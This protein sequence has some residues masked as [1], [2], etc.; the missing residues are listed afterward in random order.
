MGLEWQ[1]IFENPV[2]IQITE[3]FDDGR[4][5]SGELKFKDKTV[6]VKEG[7]PRF[8][9]D[10]YA[11]NFGIQW[12]H[13]R[14]TQFDSYTKMPL[15]SKRFWGNTKWDI[16]ELTGKTVLEAGC[17]AG[18]FTEILLEAGA[19]VVSFDLSSAVDA[20]FQ[21]N[22]KKGNLLVFQASVYD[23]PVKDNF[24]DYVFCYGVLQHTPDPNLAYK[25]IF[26]KLRHGGKISIDY[27]LK[28]SS[29]KPWSTPKHLWRPLTSKMDPEKLL[30]IIKAYIPLWLPFDTVIKRIPYVGDFLGALTCIPCWNYYY[31]PLGQKEKIEWAIMDTFDALGAFYDFPKTLEEVREMVS[32]DLSQ[33]VD[34]FYGSNGVVANVQK[35]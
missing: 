2:S 31:L 5:K 10:E 21:A 1:D 28:S 6:P 18:R 29:L 25:K 14:Q 27:Y 35:Q 7:I 8:S 12:N 13:F 22:S 33:N 32:L 24:F 20:N 23:L 15:T 17:G 34:V 30:K 16:K 19:N 9:S 26:N 3:K 11:R 4:I